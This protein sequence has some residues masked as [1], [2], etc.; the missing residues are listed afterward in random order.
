[1]CQVSLQGH[2]ISSIASLVSRSIFAVFI[3]EDF[4]G[5]GFRLSVADEELLVEFDFSGFAFFDGVTFLD[6][7]AHGE[8]PVELV[9]V[10]PV[11]DAC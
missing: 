4:E 10:G 9:S 5:D 11:S 1:M 3:A 8:D 2:E 6:E 7:P